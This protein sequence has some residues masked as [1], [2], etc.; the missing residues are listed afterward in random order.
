MAPWSAYTGQFRADGEAYQHR[1]SIKRKR[2]RLSCGPCGAQKLKCD[3][4][5]P[6]ETCVRQSNEAACTYDRT[7]KTPH[8]NGDGNSES[9]DK[10]LHI[11]QLVRQMIESEGVGSRRTE[12]PAITSTQIDRTPPSPGAE[13][14]LQQSSLPSR[15]TG[16]THWT[17]ILDNI[18]ELRAA[19]HVVP[20]AYTDSED[21]VNVGV[22]DGEPLFGSSRLCSM[23]QILSNSLPP[24]VQVDR[25]L[26]AFFN[27]KILVIPYIHVP[28]FQRQYQKFWADPL[29]ASPL[30]VS[31]LF[32]LCCMAATISEATS[33]GTC[34]SE[35]QPNAR[36]GFL[37]A[38]AQCL[39]LGEFSRPQCHV[40]E[41]LALYAQ[42]KYM[43]SLDPSR[44]LCIILSV[45]CRIAYMMGYHRD[46]DNFSSLTTFEGEMRR[47]AWSACRHFDLMVSFQFGLPS[48][49]P[50]ETLDTKPPRN[51]LDS[52]FD[53]DTKTL[54]TS[55]PETEPTPILYFVV[56]QTLLN[57]VTKVCNHALS[58]ATKSQAEVLALDAEL[59]QT[60]ATIPMGL[61]MRP[62]E[63]CLADPPF[64]IITRLYIEFL[65]QKSLCILHRRHM[66]LGYEYSRKA[67]I[68]AAMT[69]ITYL[70]D[71]NKEYQPGGQLYA[72]R[73]ALSSFTMNDFLLAVMILCLSLCLWR[74][75]N[76]ETPVYED[77][78]AHAQLDMLQ[79]SYI[80]CEEK[81]PTSK[82]SR[83]VVAAV[84]TILTQ[85]ELQ[86]SWYTATFDRSS[87]GLDSTNAFSTL[88]ASSRSDATIPPP[89]DELQ[90]ATLASRDPT[91]AI[92]ELNPFNN[93]FNDFENVDWT[94]LTQFLVSSNGYDFSGESDWGNMQHSTQEPRIEG[95][96]GSS[97]RSEQ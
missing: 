1:K 70:I 90:F 14:H 7:S 22:A 15:Y 18:Q 72:E 76:P 19:M 4:G 12:S 6:C 35:G 51:L 28:Q 75:Q 85:F 58:L 94:Q 91:S 87:T 5:H 33:S 59:R 71:V 86:P 17:A 25:R 2:P 73:W 68:D 8:D 34:K 41:A 31:M 96:H 93:I 66:V 11:E 49:V 13:G 44:E 89:L 29:G 74:R 45:V 21:L 43:Y 82:E 80:V 63:Q 47:R 92:N 62:I 30:W 88:P 23:Q 40:V 61:R 27:A 20:S 54:P 36:T 77:P 97:A 95:Q 84:K 32:S 16:S 79:Q 50:I 65:H 81:S 83:R 53:E 39:V 64:L 26:S 3:R 48:N 42:C 38:A 69:I 46:P 57:G 24:K 55:R 9:Q 78:A 52:D 56:K 10:L 37:E 60:Y 67:C